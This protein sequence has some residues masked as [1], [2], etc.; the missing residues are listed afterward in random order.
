[1]RDALILALTGSTRVGATLAQLLRVFTSEPKGSSSH[2]KSPSGTACPCCVWTRGDQLRHS[3]ADASTLVLTSAKLGAPAQQHQRP[4]LVRLSLFLGCS[5]SLPWKRLSTLEDAVERQ[6]KRLLERSG[7][8]R[9]AHM[10]RTFPSQQHSLKRSHRV[11]IDLSCRVRDHRSKEQR[12][13][14]QLQ[15]SASHQLATS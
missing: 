10:L 9:N 7:T 15:R 2:R 12:K 5:S 13:E 4:K 3:L 14:N 8:F 6:Q 11:F 1:M